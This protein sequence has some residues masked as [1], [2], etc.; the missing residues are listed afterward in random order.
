[1]LEIKP[2][3]IMFDA[4]QVANSN[5]EHDRLLGGTKGLGLISSR[6]FSKLTN[7]SPLWELTALIVLY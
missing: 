7:T 6:D 3:S 1:M 5:A 2:E 4:N